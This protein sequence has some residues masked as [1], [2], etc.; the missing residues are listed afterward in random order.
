MKVT[1]VFALEVEV[2]GSSEAAII[3]YKITWL[4]NFITTINFH[5][6]ENLESNLELIYI[7]FLFTNLFQIQK[8]S[9]IF[10]IWIH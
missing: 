10:W 5:Q 9:L 1:R 8:Y 2:L 3:T 4:C 7:V 6:Y